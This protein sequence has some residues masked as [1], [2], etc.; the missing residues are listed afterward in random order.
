M[1]SGGIK[2][3]FLIVDHE[4]RLQVVRS[5]P[6]LSEAFHLKAALQF[7]KRF[8]NTCSLPCSMPGTGDLKRNLSYNGCPHQLTISLGG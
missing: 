3:E 4:T 2:P 7:K 1:N 6:L 5:L 8:L